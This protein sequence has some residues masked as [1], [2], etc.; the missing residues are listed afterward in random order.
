MQLGKN[1]TTITNVLNLIQ[2][3]IQVWVS[4]NNSDQIK[5]TMNAIVSLLWKELTIFKIDR[6]KIMIQ[7]LLAA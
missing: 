2:L 4:F 5:L 1:F 7:F 3:N 6:T